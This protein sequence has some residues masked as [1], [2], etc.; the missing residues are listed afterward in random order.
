[1]LTRRRFLQVGLGSAVLLGGTVLITHDR[2]P[3]A[4]HHR[5]LSGPAANMIHALTP[6]LLDGTLPKEGAAR[7]EA[8]QEVVDAFDRA[9][10]GLSPAVQKELQQLLTLLTFAPTRA[11]VGGVWRN[12][13]E[14]SPEQVRGFL[15]RWRTSRIDLLRAGYQALKQVMQASWYGNARSWEIIGYSLPDRAKALL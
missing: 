14:A 13:S 2:T 1:M 9:L 6:V 5:A 4:A 11:L 12:W 10:A 8:I 3:A 15:E 7:Q